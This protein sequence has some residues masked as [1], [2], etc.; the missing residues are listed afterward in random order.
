M[1]DIKEIRKQRAYAIRQFQW[2]QTMAAIRVAEGNTEA[3]NNY[4]RFML[5]TNDFIDSCNKQLEDAL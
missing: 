3:A 5:E 1:S 2:F 4:A